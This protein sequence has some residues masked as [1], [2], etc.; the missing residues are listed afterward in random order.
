[1]IQ[2]SPAKPALIK[3]PTE[4]APPKGPVSG[5]ADEST[6]APPVNS[7]PAGPEVA[8][9]TES[10]RARWRS[11][12]DNP[13]F[14]DGSKGSKG[15]QTR[16]PVTVAAPGGAENGREITPG[17]VDTGSEF[18]ARYIVKARAEE[19]TLALEKLESDGGPNILM[20]D[21]SPEEPSEKEVPARQGA[22][23]EQA[24]DSETAALPSR[25]LA[26][27]ASAVCKNPSPKRDPPAKNP[28]LESGLPAKNPSPKRGPA[29]NPSPKRDPPA[30]DPSPKRDPPA[31][32]PSPKRNG[33]PR[34][35]QMAAKAGKGRKG[36][37]G[38]A[39]EI[40]QIEQALAS[41]STGADVA[42]LG[43]DRPAGSPAVSDKEVDPNSLSLNEVHVE[44]V[45]VGL[46]WFTRITCPAG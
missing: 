42:A 16:T 26:K 34:A 14:E 40:K 15:E 31:K 22:A 21:Q 41:L 46:A 20:N 1:V 4:P 12:A 23:A 8:A 5:M 36:S 39:F 2:S 30:K 38:S 18:M 28:S 7:L 37:R 25:D 44:E 33:S 29:K 17:E 10:D 9:L 43:G 27:D 6:T 32:N 45:K 11:V 3:P 35:S 24:P 13:A 19:L